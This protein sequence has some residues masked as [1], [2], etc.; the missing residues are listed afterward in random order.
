MILEEGEEELEGF[1]FIEFSLFIFFIFLN[2]HVS[3]VSQPLLMGG[4]GSNGIICG[5]FEDKSECLFSLESGM[6]NQEL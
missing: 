2:L 5:M 4:C 3:L 6:C 1:L